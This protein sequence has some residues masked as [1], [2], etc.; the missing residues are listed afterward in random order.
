[1]G[2]RGTRSGLPSLGQLELKILDLLWLKGPATATQLREAIASDR[3]LKDPTVRTVLRRLEAK[4]FVTRSTKGR[5]HLYRCVR[6]RMRVAVDG[7]REIVERYCGG[8]V[9]TLLAAMVEHHM[10]GRRELRRLKKLAADRIR[11]PK[12]Q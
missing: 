11:K 6:R 9:D 4:G 8:S 2:R 12:K 1:M 10:I 5:C 3:P 7:V